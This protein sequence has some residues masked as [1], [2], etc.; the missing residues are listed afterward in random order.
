MGK[1]E[2][3]EL[4]RN[5]GNEKRKE[6]YIKN[7][8]SENTFGVLLGEL[9]KI[10]KQ[11]KANHELGLELWNSKNTDAQWLACMMLDANRLTLDEVRSMV[12]RLTYKDLIDKFIGEVVKN[13]K[14][15]E[16][17]IKEWT[18]S[19]E[20]NLGRAG[21]NL[22]VHKVSSGRLT[23]VEIETLLDRIENELQTSS[24]GKQWAMNYALCQI[25]ISYDKYT[26]R[27]INLGETLGVYKDMK[28]PKGCTS[29]YAPNWIEAVR[30][31]KNK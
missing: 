3:L 12:S 20:D 8:A 16:T 26:E 18:D 21:W 10:A 31:K 28:V 6:M 17:L 25:G 5:L 22:I 27:C 9:R 29:A 11:L 1:D 24:S 23:E 13:H 2:V 19:S 15:R 7:G 4:L 30:M 14:D